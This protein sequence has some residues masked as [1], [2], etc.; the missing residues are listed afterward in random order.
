MNTLLL[1]QD[2][3]YLVNEYAQCFVRAE[4]ICTLVIYVLFNNQPLFS[5]LLQTALHLATHTQQTDMIR[6][7]LIA[8]ASLH[9]TDHKGNTPLH[10]AC[11]FSSPK[12]LDEIL[13]YVSLSTLLKVSQIRN[14]DGL[15]CVHVAAKYGNTDTLRKLKNMGVDMNMQVRTGPSWKNACLLGWSFCLLT[16]LW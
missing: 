2:Q 1:W 5:L 8:G 14:N 12:C 16:F 4:N 6:K 9:L 10:V 13:R 11:K 7:L 3:H 15:T